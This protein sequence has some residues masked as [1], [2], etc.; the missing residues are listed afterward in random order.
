MK[1]YKVIEATELDQLEVDVSNAMVDGWEPHGNLVAT[2]SHGVATQFY[3]PMIL[4]KTVPLPS[5]NKAP[6]KKP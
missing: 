3:Q 2:S 6:Q 5:L 4:P 1:R